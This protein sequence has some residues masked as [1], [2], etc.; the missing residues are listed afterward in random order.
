M[1]GTIAVAVLVIAFVCVMAVAG[2]RLWMRR[3]GIRS[4]QTMAGRAWVIPSY[5]AGGEP[6]RVLRVS[7]ANQSATYVGDTLWAATPSVYI[8]KFD[9]VFDAPIPVRNVLM[10]G[11]GGFSFPK[12]LVSTHPEARVDVVEI[13]PTIVSLAR[14]FFYLDRLIAEY[15]TEQ[16]G[17]LQIFVQDACEYLRESQSVYDAVI[18]DI[19][20]GREPAREFLS[21][22]TLELVRGHLKSGGIYAVNVVSPASGPKSQVL[23]DVVAACRG[24][25]EYVAVASCSSC[26]ERDVDNRI[27][28]ASDAPCEQIARKWSAGVG[29]RQTT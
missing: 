13:D 3:H 12:Q 20:A 7:G 22:R 9:L 1:A 11:G 18:N 29:K 27:V 2:V 21:S 28:I 17:R 6:T 26:D 5:D 19:F 23:H 10:L 8:Q 16:T 14:R 15:D 4:F 24:T 25:F